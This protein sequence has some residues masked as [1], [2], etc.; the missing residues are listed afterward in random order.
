MNRNKF[1]GKEEFNNIRKNLNLK[2]KKIVLCH[3][4]FDLIHPGHIIHFEEAKSMGD[5]LVVSLTSSEFVIKGPDRPYFNNEHRIKFLSSIDCIDYVLLSKSYTADDIIET[6]KPDIYVKGKEYEKP[7]DD[8]TGKIY[9]E[10]ELVKS[11]GGK[12]KY[13]HGETF[14]STK[15][16]NNYFHSFSDELKNFIHFLKANYSLEDL[17]NYIDKMKNLKVLVV[18][19]AIIDEYVFCKVQ[20]IMSKD[21]G[22]SANYL[23]TE[24]YLGGVLAVAKDISEFSENVTIMSVMGNETDIKNSLKDLKI[25]SLNIDIDFNEKYASILKRKYVIENE[26]REE[27]KKVF[28]INN[29]AENPSI[30]SDIMTNFKQRLDT[31]ISAYDLVVICD[32]GHGIIDNEVMQIIETKGKC[33]SINCQTNSSNFGRNI[34]TKYKNINSFVLDEKELK[35]AIPKYNVTEK[36]ALN[37]LSKLLKSNGFLTLGAKGAFAIK[38]GFIIECP[39]LVYKVKDTIGAGDAFFSISS[40]A[41]GVDAP[42]EIGLLLGSISAALA[43]NIYGNKEHIKKVNILKYA[44]TLL[45]I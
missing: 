22:Y 2:G 1:V 35:L 6:V 23:K 18:G 26:K 11:F 14:S 20:G 7:E 21:I 28:A 43:T 17:K 40:L 3:G 31:V 24:K 38:D 32:F 34:I 27:L 4:V 25:N 15:L 33:I 19:D 45:N 30:N 42:M 13:T 41:T 16:I 39:A 9:E 44:T 5:V 12:I 29:V 10:T 37:I 8:L 36:E